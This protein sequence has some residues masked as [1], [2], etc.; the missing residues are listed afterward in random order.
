MLLAFAT[1]DAEPRN[2]ETRPAADDNNVFAPYMYL[3][4]PNS[5]YICGVALY[6]RYRGHGLGTRL[7]ELANE[8]AREKDLPILS[9]V[10]RPLDKY[11]FRAA[12]PFHSKALLADNGC[13]IIK[14]SNAA[15]G[16]LC[17]SLRVG[18]TAPADCVAIA[19]PSPTMSSQ[20][21]LAANAVRPA[22]P[23][24]IKWTD[25]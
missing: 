3:E 17:S 10:V 20:Q 1:P 6:P 5:W 14:S 4:E 21:R 18:L 16:R 25:Y 23:V 8:Q 13:S 11:G 15:V 7:M 2:P 19:R 9:L 22:E 24:L 12:E